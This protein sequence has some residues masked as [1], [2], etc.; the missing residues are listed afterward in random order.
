MTATSTRFQI[1]SRALALALASML[2]I[3]PAAKAAGP[4]AMGQRIAMAGS[5]LNDA[6]SSSPGAS[7][8]SIEI[9]LLPMDEP[10]YKR[11]VAKAHMEELAPLIGK[12]ALSAFY[13]AGGRVDGKSQDVCFLLYNPKGASQLTD[14]FVGPF[15]AAHGEALAPYL[16]LAAHE[17]GHCIEFQRAA[18]SGAPVRKSLQMEISADSFAILVMRKAGVPPEQIEPIIASRQSAAASHRTWPWAAK[19][20]S[21]PLPIGASG[22]IEDAWRSAA[23]LG[24]EA[25]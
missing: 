17:L 15:E 4:D 20:L 13:Q 5:W 25:R 9:Q 6:L 18:K 3:L 19:A 11:Y 22:W 1:K 16:F 7:S 24:S 14:L 10:G 23:K 8:S 12:P 2:G 21:M